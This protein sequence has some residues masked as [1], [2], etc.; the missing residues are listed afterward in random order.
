MSSALLCTDGDYDTLSSGRAPVKRLEAK[1]SERVHKENG[2]GKTESG[3]PVLEQS[4][5]IECN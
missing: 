1:K 2:S 5:V 3:G 4:Q